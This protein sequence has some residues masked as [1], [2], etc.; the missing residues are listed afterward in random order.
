MGKMSEADLLSL[1]MNFTVFHDGKEVEIM[2][3]GAGAW[4]EPCLPLPTFN[5]GRL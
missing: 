2:E 1:D 4:C 5:P 3:N